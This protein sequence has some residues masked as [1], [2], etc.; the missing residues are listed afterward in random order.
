MYT[1]VRVYIYIYMHIGIMVARGGDGCVGTVLLVLT[2]V[3]LSTVRVTRLRNMKCCT[4]NCNECFD[5]IN[6]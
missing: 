2:V 3:V 6:Q 4:V 5:T 1:F